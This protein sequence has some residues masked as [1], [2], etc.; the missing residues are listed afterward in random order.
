MRMLRW[1]LPVDDRWHKFPISVPPRHAET[2]NGGHAVEFWAED[3][4]HS[5]RTHLKLR[6]F[7]TGHNI[8]DD[9]VHYA[10]TAARAGNGLVWHIYWTIA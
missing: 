2:I 7:G 9:M 8:P 3:K 10:C 5:D 1:E 4:Q 6:V